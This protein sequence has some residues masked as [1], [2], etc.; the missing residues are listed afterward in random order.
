MTAAGLVEREMDTISHYPAYLMFSP[1]LFRVG[2]LYERLSSLRLLRSLRGSI[3]CVFEKQDHG[4]APTATSK[5]VNGEPV[6]V[7]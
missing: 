1:V 2:V 5:A 7:S 3:L 6:A 4:R